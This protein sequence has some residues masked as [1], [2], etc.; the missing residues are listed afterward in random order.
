MDS[1]I[2]VLGVR[3]AG[4]GLVFAVLGDVRLQEEGK[5]D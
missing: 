3:V 5:V 4:N 2:L 1:L